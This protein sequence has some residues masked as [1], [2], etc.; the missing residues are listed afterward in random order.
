MILEMDKITKKLNK[1]T[2]GEISF[3]LPR[4]YL[5]GLVGQ[6]GAGKTTLLN[7]I[8]GLYQPEEGA[9]SVFG[10]RYEREEKE[11][12]DRIGYVL[13]EELFLPAA[14]LTENAERYGRFYSRYENGKMQGYLE[15]F[16]L[17][18]DQKFGKTSRGEKLKFQL[19][20]ALSVNPELLI[21]DEP[22]GNFDPEFRKEF[23]EVLRE[24][25][26]DGEKSVI[27]ATHLTEDLDTMADYLIYLE[28]GKQIYAGDMEHFRDK[29]RI[30]RG[31]RYKIKL[32]PEEKI[33]AMEEKEY[34]TAALVEHSRLNRYDEKLSVTYPTI[35]EFM[36]YFSKRKN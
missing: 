32:L 35:E 33:L 3:S 5:C 17:T 36:Y 21:L 34:G 30:V 31:E 7:L 20:F 18:N 24:Y 29:Y 2:L 28:K 27:L 11:I 25:L 26:A 1:F 9:L 14:T 6:N 16:E 23:W 10:K 12:H 8:M 15:R 22:A 13:T 19:A 4:G